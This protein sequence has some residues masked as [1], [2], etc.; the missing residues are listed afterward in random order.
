LLPDSFVEKAAA[1][2][3]DAEGNAGPGDHAA[4]LRAIGNP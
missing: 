1:W 2:E 4:I 3:A